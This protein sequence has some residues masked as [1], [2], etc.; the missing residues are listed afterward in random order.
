MN[1]CKGLNN[2]VLEV[3]DA[4]NF[5]DRLWIF[6]EL[7]STALTEIIKDMGDKKQYNENVIK[8]MLKETLKGLHFLHQNNI[9][10]RDIK[11]DN[12]LTDE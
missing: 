2:S 6:V 5:A 7:M 8:Y 4:Y 3:V 11:S 10:H 12:I 1:M 9:V